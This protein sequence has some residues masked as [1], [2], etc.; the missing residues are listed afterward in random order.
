MR[1]RADAAVGPFRD[2]G[3]KFVVDPVFVRTYYVRMPNKTISVPVDV[4]PV[5]EGLGVPFSQWVT[6]RLREHAA[7]ENPTF[8][9]QL[10][11]DAELAD[12]P[13]Q[14]DRRAVGE[15]MESSAPW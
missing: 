3:I 8:V 2:T 12:A 4:L 1:P 11:A 10:E 15:R 7:E 6:A 14:R 5:I 9:E 13:G